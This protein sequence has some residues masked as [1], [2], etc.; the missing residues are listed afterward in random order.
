MVPLEI[1]K[2]VVLIISITSDIGTALA[3][4]YSKRGYK[5]IG[6]YRSSDNLNGLKK[7]LI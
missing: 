1:N 2:K 4:R 7:I 6:T 5:I 3:E